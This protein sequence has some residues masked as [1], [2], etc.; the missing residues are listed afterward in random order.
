MTFLFLSFFFLDR[1]Y[2]K[3]IIRGSLTS[4]NIAFTSVSFLLSFDFFS[5]KQMTYFR[6][7]SNTNQ[8]RDFK[9]KMF[10][11][12]VAWQKHRAAKVEI[13]IVGHFERRIYKRDSRGCN[14]RLMPAGSGTLRLFLANGQIRHTL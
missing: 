6:G 2:D 7:S 5:R 10:E 4:K 3:I 11:G 9:Q 14:F 12:I 1:R 8:K 13:F